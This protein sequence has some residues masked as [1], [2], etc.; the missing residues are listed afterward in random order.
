MA[1][2]RPVCSLSVCV[3]V[4]SV[5]RAFLPPLLSSNPSPPFCSPAGLV[6]CLP[7]LCH[8]LYVFCPC[9]LPVLLVRALFLCAWV[10][11]CARVGNNG[12]RSD[13]GDDSLKEQLKQEGMEDI[14]IFSGYVCKT[15]CVSV[16]VLSGQWLD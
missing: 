6:A 5:V 4:E 16:S 2:T 12:Q 14:D 3:S 7:A 1:L 8:V 11:V 13:S 15:D 9:V 10:A